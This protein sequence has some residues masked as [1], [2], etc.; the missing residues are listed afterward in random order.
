[1]LDRTIMKRTTDNW[2]PNFDGDEVQVSLIKLEG[3]PITYR[4]CVWGADDCGM[5]KDF[6]SNDPRDALLTFE[7]IERMGTVTM[8]RLK[9][10]GFI[11]A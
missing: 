4:V 10:M 8:D 3:K 5:E 1:M 7:A 6:L 11:G 9:N 2:Y